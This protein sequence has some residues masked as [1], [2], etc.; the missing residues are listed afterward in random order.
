[1]K[2]V[3]NAM[4]GGFG[5]SEE[6]VT[7]FKKRHPEKS[8][9]K[10]S[11][12]RSDPDVI[13]L[14]EEMGS[15][16]SSGYC[17]NLQIEKIPDD[18]E[19]EIGEYDGMETVGWDVPKDAILQDLV[20]MLKGRKKEEDTSKFTQMLLREDCSMYRLRQLVSDASCEK[21]STT[22]T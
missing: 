21:D 19:F 2:V 8:L 4:Y 11:V 6:F 12:E 16:E 1:M 17:A 14:L 22:K 18:V 3:Y 10:W 15:D 20:D 5:F 13:A 9:D 7:E